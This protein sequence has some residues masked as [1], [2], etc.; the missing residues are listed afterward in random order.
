MIK[1]ISA[2]SSSILTGQWVSLVDSPPALI[3]NLEFSPGRES[4][5]IKQSGLLMF[6]VGSQAFYGYYY[7]DSQ[8]GWVADEDDLFATYDIE[9]VEYMR[10]IE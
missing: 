6:S 5:R 1:Q 3:R 8:K 9:S 4:T 7:S 10:I 2:Q